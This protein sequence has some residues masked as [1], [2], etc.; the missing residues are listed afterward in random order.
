MSFIDRH[1]NRAGHRNLQSRQ[2]HSC[3]VS[4]AFAILI[5]TVHNTPYFVV[6]NLTDKA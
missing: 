2:S 4:K 5:L 6:D 3:N 1:I